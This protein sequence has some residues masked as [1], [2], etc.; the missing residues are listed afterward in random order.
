MLV[1]RPQTIARVLGTIVLLLTLGHIIGGLYVYL[2]GLT[3]IPWGVAL[4]HF[5]HEANLPSLYSALA[6]LLAGLLLLA[7]AHAEKAGRWYRYWLGL[8]LVFLFLATDE[9][10]M[11]HEQLMPVLRE[12]F[13]LSGL[14]YFAWVIPYGLGLLGLLVI[15]ARFIFSLPAKTRNLF[16]LSGGIYVL[17]ALVIELFEGAQMEA[18]GARNLRYQAL[19]SCEELL[20]MIGVILFIY[21]LSDYIAERLPGLRIGFGNGRSTGAGRPGSIPE[22]GADP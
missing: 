17:G 11:I 3:V 5:D 4:F 20:E 8:G 6:L 19:M 15:Y 21:A 16:L 18:A 10:V 2:R 22:H 13:G 9:A 1:L 12:A 7:I 14:L